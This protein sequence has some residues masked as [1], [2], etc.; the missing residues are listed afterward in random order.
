MRICNLQEVNY[1][2]WRT[3]EPRLAL[4]KVSYR[5][6]FKMNNYAVLVFF[7]AFQN[8]KIKSWAEKFKTMLTLWW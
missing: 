2:H 8:Q 6:D 1:L 5:L 7:I 4:P 3:L